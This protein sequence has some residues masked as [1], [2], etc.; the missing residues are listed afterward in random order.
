M[1]VQC[2]FRVRNLQRH[3]D[4]IC[5]FNCKKKYASKIRKLNETDFSCGMYALIS[6]V[7]CY[8]LNI[9]NLLEISLHST[10]THVLQII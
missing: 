2:M 7:V 8:V 1:Y 3:A 10:G 9:C 4:A 6:V 5:V